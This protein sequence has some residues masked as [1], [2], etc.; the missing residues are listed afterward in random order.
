MINPESFVIPTKKN[1]RKICRNM[2]FYIPVL[3]TI[4]RYKIT[5]YFHK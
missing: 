4:L 3:K 5:Y 2:K 1:D